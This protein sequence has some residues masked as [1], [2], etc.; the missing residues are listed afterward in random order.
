[1]ICE[2]CEKVEV[3]DKISRVDLFNFLRARFFLPNAVY[4]EFSKEYG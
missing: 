4:S 1:M 2:N 3:F